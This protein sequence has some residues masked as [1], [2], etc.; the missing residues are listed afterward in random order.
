MKLYM[1]GV[2]CF[3][4]LKLSSHAFQERVQGLSSTVGPNSNDC[5]MANGHALTAWSQNVIECCRASS[6]SNGLPSIDG[7]QPSFL[8]LV[9]PLFRK[10]L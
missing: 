6:N 4:A 1:R 10:E 2:I 9:K 5:C 3:C 8:L 7:L